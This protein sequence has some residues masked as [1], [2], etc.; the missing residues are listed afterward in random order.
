MLSYHEL[1]TELWLEIVYWATQSSSREAKV[2]VTDHVPFQLPPTDTKDSALCTR[3]ALTLVCRLWRIWTTNFLYKD[4]RIRHGARALRQALENQQDYG[5][6]VC[7][8]PNSVWSHLFMVQVHRAVL[9]YPSTVSGPSSSPTP[10]SIDILRHCPHLEVLVRP[11]C[12]LTESLQFEFEVGCV[13]LPSLRRL[14]WWHH[15]EAERS[16]GINSLGVVLKH[17]PNIEYLFIGG[18]VGYTQMTSVYLPSLRTLRLHVISGL[19]LHQIVSQWILPSMTHI[20]LDS[21]LAEQGLHG[22]WDRFGEQLEIVEFG[23]HLRFLRNDHLT[24]CLRGCPTLQ[25][26]GYFVFF[27]TVPETTE[28]H[29][30]IRTIRLHSAVNHFLQSAEEIWSFLDGHFRFCSQLPSLCRII[31]HGEWKGILGQTRFQKT[32]QRL[33]EVK[34]RAILEFAD[35]ALPRV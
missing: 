28:E 22:V 17:V 21:P 29:T 14:E 26:I 34:G 16:G 11:R 31:L 2:P 24:V 3:S 1:P 10:T 8:T 5:R 25:E 27:T 23:K 30:S 19:L 35:E 13:L 33:Y 7:T 20:I 12:L 9:P 15:T 18:V 6:M 4:I 32:T